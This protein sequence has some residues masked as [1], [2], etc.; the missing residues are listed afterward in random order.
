MKPLSKE[1]KTIRRKYWGLVVA[2]QNEFQKACIHQGLTVQEIVDKTRLSSATVQR[3]CDLGT[4][5]RK[6]KPYSWLHG[7]YATTV[8]AIADAIGMEIKATH[9]RD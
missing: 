2:T 8:F 7:P 1:S 9:K 4:G 5:R 3:F 6:A